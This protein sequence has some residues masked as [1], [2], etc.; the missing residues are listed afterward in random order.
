MDGMSYEEMRAS[1]T[2]EE[3][4]ALDAENAAANKGNIKIALLLLLIAAI[5]FVIFCAITYIVLTK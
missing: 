5:A 3:R 1:L 2:P 4:A